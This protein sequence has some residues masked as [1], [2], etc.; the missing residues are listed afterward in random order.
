MLE[1][2]ITG[3]E[4]E[5]LR[6]PVGAYVKPDHISTG[7]LQA[8][9]QTITE[10]PAKLEAEVVHLSDAQLDTPYRPGGWTVRQVVH[11]CADSHINSFTRF[12]LTLTEDLPTIKPYREELWAEL[13]DSKNLPLHSS[14]QI[15]KYVHERW[16]VV[17][18]AMN[19]EQWKRGFIHPEKGRRIDLDEA[20]ALYA[21]HCDHH[22]AHIT[23]LKKRMGW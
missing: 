5:A 3:P 6:F 18:N 22:L 1:T 17:L 13:P 8:F 2:I 9:L 14:L 20:A 10:F 4:L 15:L 23:S 16:V 7:Q 12:K 21:W 19:A 11:H